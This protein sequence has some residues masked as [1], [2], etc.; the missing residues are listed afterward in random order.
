MQ[1]H[2]YGNKTFRFESDAQGEPLVHRVDGQHPDSHYYVK[3]VPGSE[4]RG[5]W[6]EIEQKFD[7]S[8]NNV[9]VVVADYSRRLTPSGGGGRDGGGAQI[10]AGSDYF[11]ITVAHELGHAFGLKHNFRDRDFI[12]SYSLRPKSLSACNAEFLA[13]HPY[14]NTDSEDK[15]TP[16]PTVELLSSN[17][18]P[19]GSTSVSLQLKASDSDGLHQAILLVKTVEPHFAAGSYEVVACE[20]L[21]GKRDAD[22]QFDYDGL[23]PSHGYTSL[24]YP[25]VHTLAVYAVDTEGNASIT[26][27]DISSTHQTGENTK[28][29]AMTLD[30]H[31]GEVWSVAF[32]P[33]GAILASGAEDG[34]KLWDVA[35]RREIATLEGHTDF[36]HSVTFSPDGKTLASGARDR[37]VKLWDIVV[38]T[39]TATFEHEDWVWS[40]AFSLDGATLA[41]GAENNGLKLWDIA[42]EREIS[43]PHL[44]DEI[45]GWT[46]LSVAF[47]LDGS[48]IALGLSASGMLYEVGTG[49]EI[50][51]LGHRSGVLSV[52]F[53]PDSTTVAS[54]GSDDTIKLWNVD[55]GQIIATLG[56]HGGFVQSVAFSPDGTLLA[57]G[58]YNHTIKL[59]DMKTL[60]AMTTLEGHTDAVQSVA[61]SPDGTLLASASFDGTILLWDIA[62]YIA[63]TT[64]NSDFD[65]DGTV[66]FTDFVQFAAQFGL[67]QGD[68]GYDARFDLDGNGA[69]GFSD[70]LI[71]AGAFGS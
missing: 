54:G 50:A 16:H 7:A 69:I 41:S 39:N 20:G 11:R 59:W 71:F 62:P 65:G 37:K 33:D 63:P 43:F 24:S 13:V 3:S 15:K 6:Q 67:S 47:S 52:A 27:W 1:A 18:Y 36:V 9:Y 58:L 60:I 25:L 12:M 22:F 57:A 21:D 10:G 46:V 68:A 34:I 5:H 26:E 32:S 35:T 29:N 66:G 28:P 2:G 14:F 30:G 31:T 4:P 48:K 49:R 64:P 17:T 23:I 53:S 42:T 40:V 56:E 45:D 55:T 61:F 44:P 38:R 8:A 19:T 70:F 51:F